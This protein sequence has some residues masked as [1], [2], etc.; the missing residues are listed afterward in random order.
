MDVILSHYSNVM[1]APMKKDRL[2]KTIKRLPLFQGLQDAALGKL[3]DIA[4]VETC[5]KGRFVFTEGENVDAF[6]VLISGVAKIA[7]KA[8]TAQDGYKSLG[9]VSEGEFLG[10]MGLF[11]HLP[12]SASVIAETDLRLLKIAVSDFEHFLKDD[13]ENASTLLIELLVVLSRRLRETSREQVALFDAG[14]AIASYTNIGEL[15]EKIFSVI[16]SSIP[17]AEGGALVLY[18]KFASAYEI[19]ASRGLSPFKGFP[20]LKNEPLVDR[21][22]K[23]G[24]FF[25][26]NPSR[27]E[28]LVGGIFSRAKTIIACPITSGNVFL[29]LIALFDS[30]YENVFTAAQKNLLSGICS[31]LAPA[32]ENAAYRA[33]DLNRRRLTQ[34]RI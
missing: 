20:A 1:G 18:N 7:I 30:E 28:A 25:E 13:P 26:G 6:Y 17:S 2:S 19:K 3:L 9:T 14:K 15:L 22:A 23:A 27:D 4:H 34:Q 24:A 33:E 11:A 31:L 29:G 8:H 10:E 16:T 12:R 5:K 32:L 21:V